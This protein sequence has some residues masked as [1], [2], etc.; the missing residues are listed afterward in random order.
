MQTVTIKFDLPEDKIEMEEYIRGPVYGIALND[1]VL[2]L[3]HLYKYQSERVEAMPSTE[4]LE[5]IRDHVATL[6]PKDF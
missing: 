1:I 2:Y 4:L 6:L 5:E 3:R